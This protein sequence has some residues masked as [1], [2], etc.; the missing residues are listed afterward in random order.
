MLTSFSHLSQKTRW[1]SCTSE[2]TPMCLIYILF[3][4]IEG[5]V[6]PIQGLNHFQLKRFIRDLFMLGFFFSQNG[7]N[8]TQ[9]K[10]IAVTQHLFKSLMQPQQTIHIYTRY[11]RCI[12][13]YLC[14]RYDGSEVFSGTCSE[15]RPPCCLLVLE[16]KTWSRYFAH[17]VNMRANC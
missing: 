2:L 12:T 14:R 9:H 3:S 10:V 15:L 16:Q 5:Y 17:L 1:R 8:T 13:T 6:I 4:F 7:L 11:H